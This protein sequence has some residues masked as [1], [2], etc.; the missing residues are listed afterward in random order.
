M[1][2][3]DLLFYHSLNKI[4][5]DT[6][7]PLFIQTMTFIALF[8][9]TIH[10]HNCLALLIKLYMHD[11]CIQYLYMWI[12]LFSHFL[13][14]ELDMF[15]VFLLAC[16]YELN[17]WSFNLVFKLFIILMIYW[18]LY[19]RLFQLEEQINVSLGLEKALQN[20]SLFFNISIW[21]INN[22]RFRLWIK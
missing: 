12:C 8:N 11:S 6:F 19:M 13:V 2:K 3:N 20:N 21:L 10:K 16:V 4:V 5:T 18:P 9:N 14:M 22:K 1:H 15:L 17:F 7:I